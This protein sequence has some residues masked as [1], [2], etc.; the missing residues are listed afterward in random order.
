LQEFWHCAFIVS[1]TRCSAK[2]CGADA[3][4]RFLQ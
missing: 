3:G 4:P 1:R 2:R